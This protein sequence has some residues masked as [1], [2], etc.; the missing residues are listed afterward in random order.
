VVFVNATPFQVKVTLSPNSVE[1]RQLAA[2]IHLNTPP[3]QTLGNYR[4]SRHNPR[5]A[6]LFYSDRFLADP[7]T[8]VLEL[9][10]RV[11]NKPDSTWLTTP[12]QFEKLEQGHPGQFYLIQANRR[13]AYFTS[14][15]H[16]K[17]IR[18]DFSEMTLPLIR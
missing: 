13:Y 2:V 7:I 18:Y 11:D 3:D 17:N 15:K 16:E 12:G 9:L 4:L 8:D 6:L 1:V 10:S 14:A 5:N